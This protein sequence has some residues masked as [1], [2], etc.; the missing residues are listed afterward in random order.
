ML[1]SKESKPLPYRLRAFVYPLT[2]ATLAKRERGAVVSFWMKS[3]VQSSAA[4]LEANAI[5]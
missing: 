2:G 4:A 5:I 3:K 1:I